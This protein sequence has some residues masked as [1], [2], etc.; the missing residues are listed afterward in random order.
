MGRDPNAAGDAGGD[1]D[2]DGRSGEAAH[3]GRAIVG[4]AWVADAIFAVTAIPAAAGL[5]S[6]DSV[7]IGAALALFFV[8]IGV[9]LWAFFTALVRNSQG[10]D[11]AVVT[12]FL[13]QGPAPRGVRPHLFGA[14][15]VSLA[16][17]AGTAVANPFGVLVP[18]LPLALVGLWGARHGRFPTRSSGRRAS[19]GTGHGTSRSDLVYRHHGPTSDEET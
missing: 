6:L 17:A 15:G 4:A 8:S 10:D 19:P 5:G 11:I 1:R 16:I 18:M 9:W 14:T 3:P 2:G 7:A 13:F 12:L